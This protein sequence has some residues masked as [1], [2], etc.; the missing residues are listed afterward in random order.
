[1]SAALPKLPGLPSPTSEGEWL[2]RR[3]GS[4]ERRWFLWHA[5]TRGL[6]WLL[7][8]VVVALLWSFWF[9]VD[10]SDP[11]PA[12]FLTIGVLILISFILWGIV[13]PRNWTVAIGPREVMVERGI[14]WR[15]RVFMSYDRVQQIDVVSSPIMSR[16]DLTELVLHSAAGGVKVYALDPDDAELITARVRADKP[17]VPD[18]L[19]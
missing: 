2:I 4:K 8:F 14:A 11:V 13:Y 10:F 5:S 19:Q 1:M 3:P 18:I 12:G 16:L 17:T 7:P 6:F 15:S 9:E